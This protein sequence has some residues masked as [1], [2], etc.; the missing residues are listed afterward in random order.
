ME[1]PIAV[2][3]Y[4]SSAL[5]RKDEAPNIELASRIVELED[6]EAIQ[7]LVKQLAGKRAVQHDC[8]KVLYEIGE[9]QPA[10]IAP[11]LDEFVALLSSNNN[12]L[13]WGGM[14]ALAWIC[15]VNP[16]GIFFRITNI[17]T[18]AENGSVITRDQAMNILIRLCAES[19]YG[20]DC[21]PLLVEQ[22][23][24]CPTNQLPMY[25]E[26]SLPVIDS[27]RQE[28]FLTALVERL[29]EVEKESKRRR[30][31]KVLRKASKT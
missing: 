3:E 22:L 2:L 30:I 10:L 18:A 16:A 28:H 9:R 6:M 14:T 11:Y 1:K 8:I 26:R 25:A 27:D 23:R 21:F 15:Q 12:R 4:I 17:L 5:G 13:Q 7:E 29:P 24:S 20:A 31:E 19:E